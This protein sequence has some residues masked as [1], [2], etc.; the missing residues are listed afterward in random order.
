MQTSE[1]NADVCI[2]INNSAKQINDKGWAYIICSAVFPIVKQ[3]KRKNV[4]FTALRI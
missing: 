3:S 2:T 1:Q 4:Q